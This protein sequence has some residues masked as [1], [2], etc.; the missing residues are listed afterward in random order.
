MSI[1]PKTKVDFSQEVSPAGQFAPT[2]RSVW[3]DMR[4]QF[5]PKYACSSQLEAKSSENGLEKLKIC[6]RKI[7]MSIIR[8]RRKLQ[9]NGRDEFVQGRGDSKESSWTHLSRLTTFDYR[10]DYFCC[11][12]RFLTV[13]K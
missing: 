13:V 9:K 3:S 8:F 7:D 2:H 1:L 12:R 11:D 5:G 6:R 10:L 4:R